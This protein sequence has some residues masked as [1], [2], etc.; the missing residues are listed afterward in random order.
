MRDPGR[1]RKG[2]KIKAKQG[3]TSVEMCGFQCV[4][5][6]EGIVLQGRPL[7]IESSMGD[8]KWQIQIKDEARNAI[9]IIEEVLGED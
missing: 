8:E 1:F 5:L 3:L 2:D 9:E 7:I 6:L 4:G